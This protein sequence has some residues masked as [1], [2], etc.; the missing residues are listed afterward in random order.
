MCALSST[1]VIGWRCRFGRK[2]IITCWCLICECTWWAI[3]WI[4]SI[5][6]LVRWSSWWRS[7]WTLWLTKTPTGIRILSGTRISSTKWCLSLWWTYSCIRWISW[8]TSWWC[9]SLT[10]WITLWWRTNLPSSIWSRCWWR[11][12]RTIRARIG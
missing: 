3:C 11:T 2:M 10:I 4:S 1:T 6:I 12:I 9:S 8:W 7:L 5:I